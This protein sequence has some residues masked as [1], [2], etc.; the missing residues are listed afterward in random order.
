MP[1]HLTP[2]LLIIISG[3]SCT[4]KTTLS[5][6]IAQELHLPL[7]NRDTIKELLFDTLGIKDREWSKQLGIS[8]YK[9]LYYLIDSFIQANQAI[10]IESNFNPEFDDQKFLDLQKRYQFESVQIICKTDGE[11]LF[12]RFKKRSESDERHPGHV[13]NQN[14]NEFKE[15][16]LQGKHRPLNLRSKTLEVDTTNFENI[17]YNSIFTAIKSAITPPQKA[18]SNSLLKQ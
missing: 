1:N 4:G 7:I 8:S 12:E 9:I 6:R 17:D 11:I 13:D 2:P 14:Y 15:I 3:L 10:I 16:L 18:N 5:K